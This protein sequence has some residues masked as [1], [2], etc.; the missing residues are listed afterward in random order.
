[1]KIQNYQSIV[2]AIFICLLAASCSIS[3]R[4]DMV[5]L[6]DKIENKNHEGEFEFIIE[7]DLDEQDDKKRVDKKK[8][9]RKK[10]KKTETTKQKNTKKA[11]KDGKLMDF[12][13]KWIGTPYRGGGTTK[14]GVDCSGFVTIVYK[15]VYGVKLPRSSRDMEQACKKKDFKDLEEGDLVFF[16]N[17]PNGRVNHV[18]IFLDKETFIHASSSMGV[19]ISRFDEKYWSQRYHSGGRYE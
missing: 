3:K 9:E 16:A 15:E 5:S 7:E 18:G 2:L 1:M 13:E 14:Q 11:K 6:A 8:K 17:K 12:C 4:A 19:T 10:Q